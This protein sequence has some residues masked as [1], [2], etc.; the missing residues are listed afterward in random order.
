MKNILFIIYTYSLG[1]GAEKALTSI[2]NHLDAQKYN[3]DIIEYAQYGFKTERPA[4]N[5]HLLDPIVS[6][7]HDGRIKRLWKNIQAFSV[8]YFLKHYRKHYDLE[9]SFNYQI[10]SFLLSGKVPAVSWIHGDINDLK[11]RPYFRW[12]QRKAFRRVNQIVAVS[13]N[14]RSSIIS[15]YPEFADKTRVIYNGFDLE[16][17]RRLSRKEIK[18]TVQKPAIAF[19]GRLD[20]NKNPMALLNVVEQLRDKGKIVS[21]YYLGEGMLRDSLQARINERHLEHQVFLLGYQAN[22]YPIV[23]QCKAVCM[24]SNSEGFPTVF[25]EGMALGVPFIS[26]PV[27]GV[28]ELSGGG[29]CGAIVQ[30][31]DECVE[32]F[33]RVLFDEELHRRMSEACLRHIENFSLQTQIREIEQLIDPLAEL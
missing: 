15:I 29:R 12:L 10:P 11:R 17:I 5:I 7:Q 32:A 1:G 20:K 16:R 3:I 26:T 13:E 4:P 28:S 14:T 9:V 23:S 21:L 27:G 6:M 2:V 25:A 8:P 18:I 19:V 24:M 22:P 30:N 33:E 31:A